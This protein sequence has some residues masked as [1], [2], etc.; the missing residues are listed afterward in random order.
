MRGRGEK[1]SERKRGEGF[2]LTS[3]LKR[4][5]KRQDG[6]IEQRS[7]SSRQYCLHKAPEMR[8]AN[9]VSVRY[10]TNALATWHTNRSSVRGF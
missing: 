7:L 5:R 6:K 4:L 10:G 3:S 2:K 1:Q 9:R 8:C